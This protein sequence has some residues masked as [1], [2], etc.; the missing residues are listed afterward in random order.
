MY[1]TAAQPFR[2]IACLGRWFSLMRVLFSSSPLRLRCDYHYMFVTLVLAAAPLPIDASLIVN[3]YSVGSSYKKEM[4]FFCQWTLVF[5]VDEITTLSLE[6]DCIRT[7]FD[8]CVC[9]FANLHVRSCV[10][11]WIFLAGTCG[12][13]PI[14][15]MSVNVPSQPVSMICCHCS[16]S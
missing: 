13:T 9:C 6:G 2:F 14:S 5:F 15:W 11:F 12:V 10:A 4:T 1:C 8:W 16:T 3:R 7:F